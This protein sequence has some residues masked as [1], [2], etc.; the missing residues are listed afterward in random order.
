MTQVT[1]EAD[2]LVLTS[3]IVTAHVGHNHVATDALPKL[4]ADVYSSLSALN[5]KAS[6]PAAVEPA[7]E[8]PLTH[9]IPAS[10]R[11][12]PGARAPSDPAV[13]PAK[14]IFP[15]FI[16]CLENGE[17]FKTLKRHL[18]AEYNM[19][20]EQYREKWGLPADYP[21]VARNYSQVRSELAKE[22]RLGGSA[23]KPAAPAKAARPKRG[24]AA[25]S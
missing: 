19:T 13:N 10:P 18:K 8:L 14:S 4:I 2:L 3:N 11:A 15:D 7:A 22:N 12:Y 17:K 6:A 20:P 24:T 1:N 9:P 21:M 5:G 25:R 16:V 23:P